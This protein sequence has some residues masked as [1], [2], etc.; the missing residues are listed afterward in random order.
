[1]KIAISE[2]NV[3]I[4]NDDLIAS[5]KIYL[6]K[7]NLVG[8]QAWRGWSN[9]EKYFEIG[10]GRENCAG[11]IHLWRTGE[12]SC[13]SSSSSIFLDIMIIDHNGHDHSLSRLRGVVMV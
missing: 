8:E 3:S 9:D 11:Y 13:I 12:L 4:M 10:D 5:N 6:L 2:C 1:M 7:L